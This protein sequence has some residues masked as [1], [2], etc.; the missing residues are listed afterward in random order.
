[1]DLRLRWYGELSNHEYFALWLRRHSIAMRDNFGWDMNLV[2]PTRP[3]AAELGAWV[4]FKRNTPV[5]Q[6]VGKFVERY[7]SYQQV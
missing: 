6:S 2:P 4:E 1:M 7:R 3:A 5:Q